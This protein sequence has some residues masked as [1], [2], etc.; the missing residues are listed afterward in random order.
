MFFIA[1]AQF[2]IPKNSANRVP[3]SLSGFLASVLLGNS[4]SNGCEVIIS[5]WF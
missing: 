1:M 5:L 4:H 2:Y 3:N